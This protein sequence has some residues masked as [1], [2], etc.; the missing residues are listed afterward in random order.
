MTS[1]HAGFSSNPQPEALLEW[2]GD[3]EGGAVEFV[4]TRGKPPGLTAES[5]VGADEL[6][7]RA[8]KVGQRE[9][10]HRTLLVHV[11]GRIEAGEPVALV[12]V[13]ADHR[14]EAFDAV[15]ALL[16]SLGGVARRQDLPA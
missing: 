5:T 8:R 4:V 6:H 9:G 10:V 13:A 14:D 2:L 7:A 12:G 16:E 11:T 3:G 1:V 15:D